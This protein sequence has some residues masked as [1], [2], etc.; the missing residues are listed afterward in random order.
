MVFWAV[1][2]Q[3]QHVGHQTEEPADPHSGHQME[4]PTDP[5][6]G[7]A[8]PDAPADIPA[9]QSAPP[10]EAFAG[11]EHAADRL[12]PPADM[13]AA[14]EQMRREHGGMT[15]RKFMLDRLE[16]RIGGG[17]DGY[18]WEAN[19]WLGGD[20][21]KLWIKSEGEGAFGG[22]LE[23]AEFQA[24]WSHAI[25]PWF[26]LQ[27]GARYDLRPHTVLDGPD[28]AH[29][30]AG[31]QGLAPYFFEIDAAAFLSD[32]GDLTARFEAEYDQRLTQRLI[33][34]PRIEAGFAARDMP[35]LGIGAGLGEIEAGLRLR[36]EIV[37][38]FAPYIGLEWQRDIGDTADYTRAAGGDPDRWL[39]LAGLRA[40][41]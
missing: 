31:I 2:L 37:P 17:E 28:R 12:F 26:D 24:L 20:I 1:P 15:T 3:A 38:E 27:L 11:P 34:Q 5:H 21:D 8:M 35:E 4:E 40:W 6:A 19:G 36:Y 22:A 30:V 16:A 10:P 41:F 39:F 29:L 25:G 13:S 7:H 14:R 33:L 23:E 9:P 32:E 18:V